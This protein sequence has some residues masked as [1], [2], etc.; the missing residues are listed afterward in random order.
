MKKNKKGF[1]IVELVIVI[2]VIAILAAVLI[3]TFSGIV[4]RANET[5]VL[6]EAKNSMTNYMIYNNGEVDVE[7]GQKITDENDNDN[8]LWDGTVGTAKWVVYGVKG[9]TDTADTIKAFVFTSTNYDGYQVV[10]D[11]TGN[12]PTVYK[13]TDTSWNN[14]GGTPA[15]GRLK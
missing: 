6:E 13:T 8:V 5:A 15:W 7:I 11:E 14:K 1:T 4:A 3:P 12:N 9:G 10:F 2:A